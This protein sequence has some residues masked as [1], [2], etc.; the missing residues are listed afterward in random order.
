MP[1]KIE[2]RSHN[3]HYGRLE[4]IILSEI[5]YM[6]WCVRCERVITEEGKDHLKARLTTKIN[7]KIREDLLLTRKKVRSQGTT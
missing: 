2:K 5:A 4:R 1:E 6:I 3:K 7:I